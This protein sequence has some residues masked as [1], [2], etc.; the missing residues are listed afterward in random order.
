MEVA[1]EAP[2]LEALPLLAELPVAPVRLTTWERI[3]GVVDDVILKTKLVVA[4]VPYLINF[5]EGIVMKNWKTTL[6]AIIGALAVLLNTLGIVEMSTD[7]Q[8]AIVSLAM[9]FVGLFS[10]DSEKADAKKT[11]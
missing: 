8:L 7:V 11:D 1:R 3:T 4:L 9:F 10:K 2:P 6:S 5:I